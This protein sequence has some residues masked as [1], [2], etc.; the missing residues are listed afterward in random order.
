[1]STLWIAVLATCGGCYALKAVG[2]WIPRRWLEHRR[3][4]AAIALLPAALLASLATSQTLAT[5]QHLVLDSRA[6][7][8]GVATVAA[9]LRAPF[10]VVIVIAAGVAAG[11]RLLGLP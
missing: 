11:L 10:L 5:G 8:V 7:G 3:A 9:L 4:T 2:L 6:A 1:M